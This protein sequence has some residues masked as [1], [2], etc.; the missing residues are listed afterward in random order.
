MGRAFTEH[1]PNVDALRIVHEVFVE[2]HDTEG[3]SLRDSTADIR[4][5]LEWSVCLSVCLSV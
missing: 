4:Q 5:S 2:E 3:M 1:L